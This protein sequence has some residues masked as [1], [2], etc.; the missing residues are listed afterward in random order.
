VV[1]CG[2]LNVGGVRETAGWTGGAYGDFR[3]ESAAGTG[4]G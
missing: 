4:V 2:Q 3:G 1:V